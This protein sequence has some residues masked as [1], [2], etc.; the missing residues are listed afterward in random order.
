MLRHIY[1]DRIESAEPSKITEKIKSHHNLSLPNNI[2]LKI[3]EPLKDFYK[4]EVRKIGM[5]L[6]ID[7]KALFRHPFP[8]PGLAIRVIGDVTEKKIEILKKAD[9]IFIEEL[10]KHNWY[11]NVWQ[12]FTALLPVRSVGVMGD[13]RTYDNMISIRAVSSTDGM[14]ADWVKL[15]YELLETV[16]NRIINEVEGVN[17]VVYDISQKPPSTIEYE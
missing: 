6:N 17:R 14:T 1:P 3:V 5:I 16:S 15:P 9:S 10:H 2:W 8:G 4:D 11:Y 12:G 7:K 13:T